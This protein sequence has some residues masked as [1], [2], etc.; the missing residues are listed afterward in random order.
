M[1]ELRPELG[2]RPRNIN[3]P[4]ERVWS[5]APLRLT[6]TIANHATRLGGRRREVSRDR[7]TGDHMTKYV[8]DASN[9]GAN[10]PFFQI[11]REGLEG[12]VEGEDYFDLLADDVVFDY[13]ISVPEYPRRVVG[14]QNVI[15]LY[16][17]YDSFLAVRSADN[18]RSYRDAAASVAILEYEVH[19]QAVR[20]SLSQSVR[21]H[22]HSEGRQSDPAAGLPRPG[23]RVRRRRL[24]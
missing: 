5:G 14:R 9:F 15:D 4:V 12:L 16:G 19:G 21:L 1:F 10:G 20:T 6:S 17:D 18:L 22:R 8:D 24:A 23:R 7:P 3:G 11:I 13:V 2:E